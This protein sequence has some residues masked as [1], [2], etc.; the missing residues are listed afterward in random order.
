MTRKR[1]ENT[2]TQ[3]KKG[4][5]RED[6]KGMTR[7]ERKSLVK[8][9]YVK[10]PRSE[11]ILKRIDHVRVEAKDALD[12]ENNLLVTAGLGA[13]KTRL[14]R[15]YEK[16]FPRYERVIETSAGPK[17]VTIV[18]VL[19]ASIPSKATDKTLLTELLSRLGDPDPKAGNTTSQTHRL[20]AL[21]DECM[22]EIML[23]DE[24]QHFIDT[25]SEKV[26]MKVANCLKDI[27][28]KAKKPIV[29]FGMP[30]S[31]RLLDENGQ[32]NRRFTK[33]MC[34]DPLAWNPSED[35]RC[36]LKEFLSR[37]DG[38]LP[39]EESSDLY[40]HVVAHCFYLATGGVV[41]KVM[42]LVRTAACFAIDQGKSR[43]GV[44][45]LSDAYEDQLA[46]V[47]PG[48]ENPFV[49][50]RRPSPKRAKKAGGRP[51]DTNRRVRASAEKPR[52]S[53]VLRRR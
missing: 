15:R 17:K 27:L 14:I 7:A 19:T 4:K 3:K 35:A 46:D 42:K 10:Y 8:K 25:D 48:K 47:Y 26:L 52:A 39:L 49:Q 44:E 41:E 43:I 45:D 5:G 21:L 34:I 38:A 29:L 40:E 2:T 24:C 6:G 18:P 28:I 22:V 12:A 30:N 23:L 50:H 36:E 51:G 16:K 33:R 9:I 20:C 53:A 13:G 32:L 31:S 11:E 1:A 37:L